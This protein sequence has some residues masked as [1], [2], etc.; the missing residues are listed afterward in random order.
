MRHGGKGPN[1]EFFPGSLG[2]GAFQSP[3]EL[4]LIDCLRGEIFEKISLG[5]STNINTNK[6]ESGFLSICWLYL[7]AVLDRY[8]RKIVGW[9]MKGALGREL[10][11]EAL[12]RAVW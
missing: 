8:I 3:E 6:N 11:L 9:S 7:A 1:S 10:A 4:E 5:K 2:K 12:L